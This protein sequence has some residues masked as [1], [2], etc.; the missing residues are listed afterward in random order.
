MTN[1]KQIEAVAL[2]IW[3]GTQRNNPLFDKEKAIKE[4]RRKC[5]TES[6]YHNAELEPHK[7]TAKAAIEASHAQY[8]KGLAEALKSVRELVFEKESHIH[9][10]N[11]YPLLD[12]VDAAL[13]ALPEE[14]RG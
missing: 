11:K 2:E 3:A 12:K 14:L 4:M 9:K 5:K 1:D 7:V 6:G 13:A 10:G 8:V